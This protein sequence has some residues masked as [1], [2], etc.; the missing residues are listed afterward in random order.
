MD[1]GKAET[2]I[3]TSAV[4]VAGTYAYRKMTEHVTGQKSAPVT[5]GPKH[6]AEGII[7]TGELLPVGTWV[8]GFGV[9]YIVISILAAMSPS[10]GGM[11]AILVAVGCEL[12]NVQALTKDLHNATH[13]QATETPSESTKAGASDEN[14]APV[15]KVITT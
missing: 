11:S 4:I 14:A 2:A 8:T 1:Q 9:T 13:K 7:G 15:Q 10:V 5:R 6:V 12:G 3:V